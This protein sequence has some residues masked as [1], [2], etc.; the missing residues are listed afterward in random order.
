[1]CIDVCRGSD[2]AL[3]REDEGAKSQFGGRQVHL[4][5]FVEDDIH[6]VL[7]DHGQDGRGN[8]GPGMGSVVR[9]AGLATASLHL[10]PTGEATAVEQMQHLNNSVIVSLIKGYKYRFHCSLFLGFRL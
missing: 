8:R 5:Q 7:I 9:F 1:M 4:V 6:A 2:G 10:S 3:H